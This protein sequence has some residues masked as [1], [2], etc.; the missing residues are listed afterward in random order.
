MAEN[1]YKEK[2]ETLTWLIDRYD[3]LRV[4]ISRRAAIVMSADAVLVTATLFLFGRFISGYVD[5]PVEATLATRIIILIIILLVLM[6]IAML[7]LS[8]LIATSSI[9][10]VWVKSHDMLGAG[11]PQIYYFHARDTYE[12]FRDF[13]TFKSRLD[14][15]NAEDMLVYAEAELWRI[16]VATY[17]RHGDLKKAIRY[18]YYAIFPFFL[19]LSIFAGMSIYTLFSY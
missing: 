6:T 4:A 5:T 10:N 9:V 13:K 3:V 7:L 18:I 15:T 8:M 12:D 11:T 17:Y 19:A 14:K 1:I 16:I 2:F